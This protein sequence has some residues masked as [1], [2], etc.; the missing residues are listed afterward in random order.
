MD[1]TSSVMKILTCG[2]EFLCI[3]N[4]YFDCGA[5]Y[6]AESEI[7]RFLLTYTYKAAEQQWVCGV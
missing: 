6:T 4:I 5:I 1:D 7:I 2:G 3:I